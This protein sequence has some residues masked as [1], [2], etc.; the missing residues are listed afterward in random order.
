[1]IWI[2]IR[3]MFINKS[4]T[5]NK[6]AIN[7]KTVQIYGWISRPRFTFSKIHPLRDVAFSADCLTSFKT[8]KIL[9]VGLKNGFR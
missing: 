1:M 6:A 9:T 8:L 3:K 5:K 7:G 2:V 4:F